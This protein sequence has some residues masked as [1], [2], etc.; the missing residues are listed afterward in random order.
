MSGWRVWKLD[1]M[2]I[3]MHVCMW[4]IQKRL[5]HLRAD[6]SMISRKWDFS[7]KAALGR[8]PECNNLIDSLTTISEA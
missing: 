3:M 4:S 6:T 2:L 8:K 7:A 5:R 1:D